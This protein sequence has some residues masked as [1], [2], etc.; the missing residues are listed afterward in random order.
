MKTL[1]LNEYG[2]SEIG[3]SEL[4]E[5]DGGAKPKS[6]TPWAVGI[7]LAEE[8]ISNWDDISKGFNDAVNGKPYNYE[9]K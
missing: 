5:I 9:K 7:W 8:I 6:W 4:L 3:Q 2:V 1:E